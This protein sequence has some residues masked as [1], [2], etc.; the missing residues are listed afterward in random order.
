MPVSPDCIPAIH[1]RSG[2]TLAL[3]LL[4]SSGC[5]HHDLIEAT[6][7]V[8]TGLE[9]TYYFEDAA[10]D[11]SWLVLERFRSRYA[12]EDPRP[13]EGGLALLIRGRPRLFI[14]SHL[15]S[16]DDRHLLIRQ[17]DRSLLLDTVSGR[18]TEL[19][20]RSYDDA[21]YERLG[22]DAALGPQPATAV[23]EA[24]PSCY[25]SFSD[26]SNALVSLEPERG[27]Y[28][29]KVFDLEDHRHREIELGPG[30]VSWV[31]MMPDG[32]SVMVVM[33]VQDP[34]PGPVP[35]SSGLTM[36]QRWPRWDFNDAGHHA[37]RPPFILDPEVFIVTR[38]LDLDGQELGRQRGEYRLLGDK[39]IR[40]TGEGGYWW[41][42]P[43]DD[44]P[45]RTTEC[46]DRPLEFD[47]VAG[48]ILYH[49]R[50]GEPFREDWEIYQ[51]GRLVLETFDR[52]IDLG[53]L[54]PSSTS[55]VVETTRPYIVFD[56]HEGQ[57]IVNLDSAAITLFPPE[58]VLAV[59]GGRA[60]VRRK[61]RA[62]SMDVAVVDLS[63][64][65]ELSAF[66]VRESDEASSQGT[67][68]T[69][70]LGRSMIDLSA[71][72]LL[73]RLPYWP[74]AV[75]HQGHA[76]VPDKRRTKRYVVS[77]D[78]YRWHHPASGSR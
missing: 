65:A 23:Y 15:A 66:T 38:V 17:P 46:E 52:T 20:A 9:G 19:S 50:D 31:E 53:P 7:R 71:G 30:V 39:L 8:A 61:S 67:G 37:C 68:T 62:F 45:R 55:S 1:A 2:W 41:W 76:L 27:G 14:E 28:H 60:L 64:G 56:V 69:I 35:E 25:Q 11:G 16:P 58:S 44:E 5:A 24:D 34:T 40:P 75:T 4:M 72:Q 22:P 26:D 18:E 32:E 78:P 13:S 6:E 59:A 47:T 21:L 77:R 36:V 43:S 12:K 33:T 48:G 63:S 3:G 51:P 49:C 74:T 54:V 42:R 29:I 73:G 57:A 70:V 10:G